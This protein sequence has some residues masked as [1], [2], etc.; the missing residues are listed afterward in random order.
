MHGCIITFLTCMN[1]NVICAPMYPEPGV[2][3][4]RVIINQ[5]IFDWITTKHASFCHDLMRWL[6]DSIEY[7]E[8]CSSKQNVCEI[9]RWSRTYIWTFN[10]LFVKYQI[11]TFSYVQI[12]SYILYLYNVINIEREKMYY[13]II[14]TRFSF[15]IKFRIKYALKCICITMSGGRES[16]IK[17]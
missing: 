12:L 10:S 7:E 1:I 14:G 11:F 16:Q 8:C 2:R 6:F 3:G 9:D 15:G 13:Q 17:C 5:Y 4:D